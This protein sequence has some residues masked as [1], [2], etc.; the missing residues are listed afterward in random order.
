MFK[1]DTGG[2]ICGNDDLK[3]IIPSV[4]ASS[5]LDASPKV[6]S[7]TEEIVAQL[8]EVVRGSIVK[9]NNEKGIVYDLEACFIIAVASE[10]LTKG[11]PDFAIL[12]RKDSDR[13]TSNLEGSSSTYPDLKGKG[14]IPHALEACRHLGR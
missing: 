8:R 11:R 10:G 13:V 14:S 5:N 12:S 2:T 3:L 9:T 7:T 1:I 6:V 4:R